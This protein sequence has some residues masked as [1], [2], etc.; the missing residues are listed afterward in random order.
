M[1]GQVD[2]RSR[3]PVLVVIAM[4]AF[5]EAVYMR[6]GLLTGASS[7]MGSD[8]EMLHRWRLA[9][10]R[11]SLFGARHFL[12]AWNPHEVLGTPFAANLQGFPWIPT[13]LILLLLDPSV[14]YAAGVG[15]AAAL[16]ALFAYLYCRRAG[17]S[18]IGAAAAGWTFA[19]A[20]YFSS[21]VMAGHLPLLEAY[22]ALPL[23]LWLVDR[24]LAPE[25]ERRRRFD[26]AA[27]ALCCACVVVAG[28]PQVPAYALLS[29]FI[30]LA[31]RGRG[32]SMAL[33][34]RAAAAMVLGIGLAL[35]AWWPMLMLI[36]RSTR[37]LRLAA[38]DNDVSMPYS[39]LLALVVPGIQGWAEP[40]ALADQNPFAGYPNNAWFWDTAS[41]VGLLP[42]IAIIA[43]LIVCAVRRRMPNWR[44]IFLA[45]I[46]TG[47][48]ICSL[49]L[50]TPLLHLLPGTFL[51][52]PA[53]LLYISTF[54][55]AVA[56][57]AGVDSLRVV[58][59]P[60]R[61]LLL[62]GALAALLALHFA[63]LW[64]F[65]HWFIQTYPSAENAPAFQSILDR[66][67]GSGRIAEEREDLVFSYGDRYDDAG[68]FDSIFLARFNRAWLALA[69]LP[70]DTNEQVFDASVLPPRAL[71]AMGVR[72]V[73]TTQARSDLQL[74]RS[75]DDAKLY[76]VANPAPRAGFIAASRAEFERAQQIPAMFASGPWDRLLLEPDARG[77]LP[78][79]GVATGAERIDY[80]RP[81][82]DEIDFAATS[83]QPGFVYVLEA[84]DPGWSATVDGVGAPVLPANGFAM[85]IPMAA[86]NHAVRLH[87]ATPGRATGE[88]LS[89][90]SLCFLIG[91]IASAKPS[92]N[93][94][95]GIPLAEY[96]SHMTSATVQQLDALSDL[97]A[98][99]L[100]HCRP[101]S[102]AVLGIA[103]GNG[104]RHIDSKVTRRVVGVD[105]NPAYL[106]SVRQ[107]Y[108]RIDGLE[109]H[110]A[111]LATEDL[112]CDPVE[113]VHAALVFEHAG[114]GR[115]LDKALRLVAPGGSLS[116]VLQLPSD[117]EPGVGAGQFASIR[118]LSDHFKLV[119]PAWLSETVKSRGF[120]MVHET[121]RPL[122]SGKAFW[123]VMFTR[124]A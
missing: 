71:E 112:A 116:V 114:T 124:V 106:S 123:M 70:S 11:Q 50:A 15:I 64:N 3:N 60:R 117:S 74:A 40:V 78:P 79:A 77:S 122:A 56:L 17:L 21:R 73:I 34:V 2:T 121:T 49:P 39:R 35:A 110:C 45:C 69:G 100:A 98:E 84:F 88:W 90:V 66:E 30:Y 58:A 120:R 23:L 86:G 46:G 8:Y 72:F 53:R 89:L 61:V 108:P 83:P 109:L 24:A 28:H 14:A 27:L 105:I 85:A 101:A 55:A 80:E 20:G 91:L 119:D 38:P 43:L 57:G 67:A 96:E 1:A 111:D 59:W 22:P 48:L 37:V 115:C 63:D 44:G 95:L 25:R 29:A 19:C 6:P 107:R 65:A 118:D 12:P 36:G 102:V 93:P 42:L 7:M 82:S 41:Y 94:W 52:S 62:N 51:R 87:Y 4:F 99:A 92:A 54:C 16:A 113:L 31:W 26:L 97:F 32:A 103:G 75:T 9:F 47:A 81:S 104:L 68:G 13:R 18:E 76:R 5:T 33:R 10:A